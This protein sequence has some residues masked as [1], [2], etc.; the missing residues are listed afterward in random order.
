VPLDRFDLGTIF[1]IIFGVYMLFQEGSV[2]AGLEFFLASAV[3]AFAYV[4]LPTIRIAQ[5]AS[6]RVS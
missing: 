4:V 5:R 3:T 6:S 2:T 1:S